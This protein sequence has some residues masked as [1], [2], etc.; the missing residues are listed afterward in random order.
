MQELYRDNDNVFTLDG[1]KNAVTGVYLNAATVTAQ[2][3][4]LEGTVVV[5]S[6]PLDLG[7]VAA[8]DGKYRIVADKALFASLVVGEYYDVIITGVESGVDYRRT[9]RVIFAIRRK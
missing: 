2:V 9:E 6:T 5:G 1:L 3:K 7:Y 8:S 4:D